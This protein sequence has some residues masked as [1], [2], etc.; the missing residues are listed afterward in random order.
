M[1]L[2]ERTAQ[3]QKRIELT[4][5]INTSPLLFLSILEHELNPNKQAGANND[6]EANA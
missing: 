3:M 6:K 4:F 5:T 2:V 1:Q